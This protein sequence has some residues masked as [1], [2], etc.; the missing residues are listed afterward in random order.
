MSYSLNSLKGLYKGII[1]G[2]SI[3][4]IKGDTRSLDYSSYR[5]CKVIAGV[6]SRDYIEKLLGPMKSTYVAIYPDLRASMLK[7]ELLKSNNGF[8]R[9]ESIVRPVFMASPPPNM[10][11]TP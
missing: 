7:W 4:G 9:L 3:G 10:K 2:T 8:S 5:D 6:P 1:Q 11:G